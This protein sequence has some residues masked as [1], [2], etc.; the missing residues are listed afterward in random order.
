MSHG[1]LV[2]MFWGDEDRDGGVGGGEGVMMPGRLQQWRKVFLQVG[3]SKLAFE[4]RRAFSTLQL[5]SAEASPR[6]SLEGSFSSSA[7]PQREGPSCQ[8]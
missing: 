3:Y 1:V 5:G 2:A 7:A 6:L 8:N 4:R